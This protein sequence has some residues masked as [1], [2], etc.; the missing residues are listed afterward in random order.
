L[1]ALFK[2]NPA[3]FTQTAAQQATNLDSI[4]GSNQDVEE[5]VKSTYALANTRVGRWQFQGGVRYE[6]TVTENK[7]IERVPDAKNPFP[8]NTVQRILYRYSPGRTTNEGEYD[9]WLP[10]A[11][12]TYRFSSDLIAKFG[13]HRALQRPNLNQLAGQWA[14]DETNQEVQIPN[15]N[16]TP[17]FSNKF[18]A[19]VDYYFE[20]AGTLGVHVFQT[21]LKGDTQETSPAPAS[22]FGYGSDPIFG[23]YEFT[24]FV[25]I[26]GTRTI[27]GIELNYRQ[28]LAFLRNEFLRRTIVFASFSQFTTTQRPGGFV[29]RAATGGV[30]FRIGKFNANVQGTWTDN[31]RTGSNGVAATA[32]YFASDIEYLKERYVVDV[33]F[34]YKISKHTDVFVSGR[35][36]FNSGKTWLYSNTDGRI[37]QMER[38]GG[39][40]T[41]G[42]RGTY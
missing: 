8:A 12:A 37:R 14:I 6:N 29:P 17:T 31:I 36:A 23:T 35:N 38:Y 9:A 34:G 5:T 42:L 26:P 21:D 24:T 13:Y 22:E 41:L 19:N 11:S 25:N 27:R 15:P 1:L 20:P 2:S 33:G 3:Y 39:Q 10:S 32:R 7:V 18:S 30:T 4:L 16:L 28:Q 40:W